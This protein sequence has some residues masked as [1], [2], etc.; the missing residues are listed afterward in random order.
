M[1]NVLFQFANL[2]QIFTPVEFIH[3]CFDFL[4]HWKQMHQH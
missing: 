3:K 1:E 4:E 2:L